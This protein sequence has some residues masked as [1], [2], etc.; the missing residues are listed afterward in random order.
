[1]VKFISKLMRALVFDWRK[2]RAIK[3]AQNDANTYRR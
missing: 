1:M 3:Q 2:K